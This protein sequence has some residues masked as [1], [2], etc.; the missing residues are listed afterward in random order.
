MGARRRRMAITITH[1]EHFVFTWGKQKWTYDY[2]IT[3]RLKSLT[4]MRSIKSVHILK[5]F[6]FKD[7][8]R[9]FIDVILIIH[10]PW[11]F[12]KKVYLMNAISYNLLNTGFITFMLVDVRNENFVLDSEYLNVDDC[13]L[14]SNHFLYSATRALSKQSRSFV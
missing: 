6:V 1:Y 2:A 13:R 10:S 4:H 11:E 3:L 5:D 12:R 14:W 9:C 7:C 8:R